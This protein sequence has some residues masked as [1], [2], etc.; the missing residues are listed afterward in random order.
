MWAEFHYYII[1][2]YID[3]I[4]YSIFY[5]QCMYFNS[6]FPHVVVIVVVVVIV[7]L[8]S[9]LSQQQRRSNESPQPSSPQSPSAPQS[10]F[11]K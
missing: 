2:P 11:S 4:N 8:F 5:Q 10:F 3:T 6:V 9:I 1:V 7:C